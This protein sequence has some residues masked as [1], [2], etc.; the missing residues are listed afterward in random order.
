M[1]LTIIHFNGELCS[2]AL[3]FSLPNKLDQRRC[4]VITCEFV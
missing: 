4:L 3:W 1:L 2:D